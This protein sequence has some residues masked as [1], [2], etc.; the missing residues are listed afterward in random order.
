MMGPYNEGSNV[1]ITCVATGGRPSPRVSWWLENA[2]IDDQYEQVSPRA[3]KNVLRLENLSRQY[4]NI[5]FTC[6]ATNNNIVAPISSAITIDINREYKLFSR[7]K[8]EAPKRALFREIF[9]LFLSIINFGSSGAYPPHPRGEGGDRE[10]RALNL[11]EWV[12]AN[13]KSVGNFEVISF[14]SRN[15]NRRR[16]LRHSPPPPPGLV[17]PADRAR[18]RRPPALSTIKERNPK[19]R[20]RTDV[21]NYFRVKT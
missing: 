11:S 20:F 6:Q 8:R 14:G 3:V 12:S 21:F 4:L 15:G 18:P 13:R 1:E 17:G 9:R 5:V 7:A 10:G 19:A 16:R 2:L